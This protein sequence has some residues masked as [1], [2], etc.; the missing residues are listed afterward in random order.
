MAAVRLLEF[1]QFAILVTYLCLHLVLH[2]TSKFHVN[3]II[4]R[5]DVAE[6]LC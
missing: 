6:K 2:P 5:L 4:R 3:R 1:S